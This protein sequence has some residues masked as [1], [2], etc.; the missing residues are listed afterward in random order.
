KTTYPGCKQVFRFADSEGLYDH[1]LV[2][3][4][5]PTERAPAGGEP[6]LRLVMQAGRR[7][8]PAPALAELR[9]AAA[10][11]LDRLP[12]ACRQLHEPGAYPVRFSA[13]LKQLLD[14]MRQQRVH[15]VANPAGGKD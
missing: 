13:A 8:E 15:P 10:A 4:A 6:L 7:V 3:R 11:N 5:D 9:A 1:D 14:A 2:A 12:H